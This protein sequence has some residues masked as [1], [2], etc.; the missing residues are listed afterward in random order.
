MA[1]VSS[2]PQRSPPRPPAPARA[3]AA[4]PSL[5]E[6]S[7]APRRELTLADWIRQG[8]SL[9]TIGRASGWWIGDWIRF[10]NARYGEKYE[11]AA[12]ITGYDAQSLMNMAY[13]ASRF[14]FSRRREKLSF[15]HHAELA[16]LPPDEQDRW[17]DRAEAERLS[18]RLIRKELR[19]GAL[20]PGPSCQAGAKADG[21]GPS[22]DGGAAAAG[23]MV[24]PECGHAFQA[25][26]DRDSPCGESDSGARPQ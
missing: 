25:S 15:S 18:S 2:V 7:W 10:G 21:S 16:A 19:R 3:P 22:R 1:T 11:V 26:S 12:R 13:V 4:G 14:D 6:T 20:P 9:G 8:R 23:V 5:T 17:L 24:C